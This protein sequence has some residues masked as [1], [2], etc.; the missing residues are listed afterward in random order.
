MRWKSARKDVYGILT[1]KSSNCTRYFLDIENDEAFD[2]EAQ[3]ND[4]GTVEVGRYI[5]S[6]SAFIK[7]NAIIVNCLKHQKNGYLI[8]DELGKL[9]LRQ[10]GFHKAAIQAI[11]NLS[12]NQN[13]HVILV[14]RTS[15]LNAIIEHYGIENYT[16]MNKINLA[17]MLERAKRK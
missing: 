6:K 1:P 14:V 3:E 10:L 11:H 2:M 9:E 5:F 7:A 17:Q 8:I 16:V 12:H 13:S 4:T 15:L